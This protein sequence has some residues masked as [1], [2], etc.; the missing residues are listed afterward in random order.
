MRSPSVFQVRGAS[1]SLT[2]LQQIVLNSESIG[3]IVQEEATL[4]TLLT[5]ELDLPDDQQ[6][7]LKE[8]QLQ[9]STVDCYT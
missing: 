7:D 1:A 3:L 8:Q 6:D 9:F 2:E 4:K 5:E